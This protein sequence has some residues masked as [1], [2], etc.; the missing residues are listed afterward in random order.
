MKN[1]KINK[2]LAS[3]LL[4][5][6]VLIGGAKAAKADTEKANEKLN[7][8]D[9]VYELKDSNCADYVINIEDV[10]ESDN[11]T[12]DCIGVNPE[13]VLTSFNQ[14][15]ENVINQNINNLFSDPENFKYLSMG[16]LYMDDPTELAL[17]ENVAKLVEQFSKEPTNLD[18]LGRLIYIFRG[19]DKEIST[20]LL[21][22]GGKRALFS[23]V[24]YVNALAHA[25]SLDENYVQA[26]D[27]LY[28]VYRKNGDVT[29]YMDSIN[30]EHCKQK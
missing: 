6:F 20:A 30:G 21:S 16:T 14:M 26:L 2:R 12:N 8:T 9:I 4:A 19:E 24:C 25:Y 27:D 3:M 28:M 1:L 18:V 5:G 10:I 17:L 11:P 22:V 15:S 13:H 29:L 23:D 7:S